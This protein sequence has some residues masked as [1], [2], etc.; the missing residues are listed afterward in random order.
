MNI[1]NLKIGTRLG[2][3][4]GL[5]FVLMAILIVL[6]LA[7]FA[8]IGKINSEM[9]DTDWVKAE[10]VSTIGAT[11]RAN[12]RR[13]MELF[14][15][16]DPA[17]VANLFEE[18]KKN[19]KIIDDAVVV[20]DQL[21]KSDAG[22]ALM[23]EFKDVR[24]KYV[25]SFGK[26]GKLVAANEREEAIKLMLNET[27][28]ALDNVQK[29]VAE[30]AALQKKIVEQSGAAAKA[31]ID[32]AT[33]MM[34]GLGIA[35][36]ILGVSF[37]WWIT[38]S[39]TK[40]MNEAV[41]IAQTVASGD[42]SS[43]IDIKSKDET[44]QL[45]QALKDMNKSLVRIVGEVRFSTDAIATAST[46]IASGNLDLSSRTEE[47]ASSLEETASSMEE[48]SS[49]VKQNADNARQANQ[50][51]LTASEVAMK[52]GNVVT[53]VVETMGSINESSKKIVDIIGVI[54][55]I[56][57]QTNILALNAAVEAARAGEQGRGFAV[58][59]AEVR[60]LAQRSA[61]AAK[62]I[63]NLIGDSVSKVN[64]GARLV[65]DAGAT[66]QEV[67]ASVRRV[68][69]IMGEIT[70]AGHE[71]TAGIE[72]IHQAVMQMDQVT[73]QNAA[74]VEEA[75]AAAESLQDQA[76]NLVQVVSVFKLDGAPSLQRVAS[77]ALTNDKKPALASS[78]T[79]QLA[80]KPVMPS[81]KNVAQAD[82]GA[83]WEQF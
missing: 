66:M 10:A 26:V 24:G 23:V 13:N 35:A 51:A 37:A 40:P 19:K 42:L 76:R 56:A 53:Q 3:G 44:G 67:V 74:L 30:L 69:D 43:V 60:T 12:A 18:I 17:K 75:A 11:I 54:D 4:F 25:V 36:V 5:V 64:D 15:E 62:E 29:T 9:I 28:P 27:L 32:S 16:S 71:Q 52:G 6:A 39:I 38:R 79:K 55:G 33:A 72:Q 61:A 82:V 8:G 2:I 58:V 83:E 1:K 41:K 46:Q 7:R 81:E 20:L 14:I 45:L 49:T 50:L 31:H 68:T 63:K 59:A 77:N 65:D 57:F 73:Q 22:K 78:T 70:A 48:L 34:I 21:I 80:N 47:Q